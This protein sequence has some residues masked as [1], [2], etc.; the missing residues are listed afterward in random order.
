MK[1]IRHKLLEQMEWSVSFCLLLCCFAL[2]LLVGCGR[3]QEPKPKTDSRPSGLAGD[4]ER[5]G[6]E[7]TIRRECNSRGWTQ[8][9]INSIETNSE[10]DW[11]A[12][13]WRLP[14]LPGGHALLEGHGDHLDKWLPGA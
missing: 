11:T 10:G 2:A 5:A 9:K 12:M 4:K 1:P 8:I 6:I 3:E 13:V 14:A 7:A